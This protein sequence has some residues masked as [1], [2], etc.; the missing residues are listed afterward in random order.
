MDAA[1][2]AISASGLPILRIGIRYRF[3]AIRSF[4]EHRSVQKQRSREQLTLLAAS[5]FLAV[6]PDRP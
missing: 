2:R 5:L 3:S 6:F 4:G 1:A